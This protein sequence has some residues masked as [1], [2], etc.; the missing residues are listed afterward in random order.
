MWKLIMGM[1]SSITA[2]KDPGAMNPLQLLSVIRSASSALCAQAALHAQLAQVEWKEEK[3]R[4]SKMLIFTFMGFA[5]FLCFMLFL[6][7]FLLMLSWDTTF[8]IPVFLLLVFSYF[9]ALVWA[10]FKVYALAQQGNNS[11]AGTRAEIE[12]DL[13]LLKRVL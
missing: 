2:G 10:A 9:L 11:F 1:I 5:C 6:G 13:A 4:L 3:L 12:A 8:R 7:A